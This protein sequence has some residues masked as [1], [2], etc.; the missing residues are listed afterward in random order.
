MLYEP[1]LDSKPDER[2]V[3]ETNHRTTTGQRQPDMKTLTDRQ[4]ETLEHIR[5]H[6]R[7]FGYPP[8]RK[9]LS[10]KLGLSH[11]SSVE[12]HLQGLQTKRWIELSP[13]TK[14]GIRLLDEASV[15]L[16]LVDLVT[17]RGEIAAGEPIVAEERIVDRIPEAVAERFSPRPDYFLTVRGD[18]MDRTG[19]RDG[20]V[21]GG[22]GNP[23]G[24]E[25][26]RGRRALR[27]RGHPQT[28]RAAR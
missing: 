22:A 21:G 13:D 15:D 9:E 24:E 7:R 27:R 6:L 11:P 17:P 23:G 8:S 3:S 20:D 2:R 14:R 10:E 25:R 4:R 5:A 12:V 18:S 19:L 26:R 16:P 28:I 1:C